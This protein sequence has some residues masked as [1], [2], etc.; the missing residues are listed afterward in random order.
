MRSLSC[1]HSM[2]DHAALTLRNL[3]TGYAAEAG[4]AALL[5]LQA[6]L[7][8]LTALAGVQL[9]E[10]GAALDPLIELRRLRH[11]IVLM[12]QPPADLRNFL[13]NAKEALTVQVDA[14]SHMYEEVRVQRGAFKKHTLAGLLATARETLQPLDNNDQWN[15]HVLRHVLAYLANPVLEAEL[16]VAP[17][18]GEYDY[19]HDL[20]IYDSVLRRMNETIGVCAVYTNVEEQPAMPQHNEDDDPLNG[21]VDD[22]ARGVAQATINSP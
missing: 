14:L 3:A 1:L 8:Q 16:T 6:A 20:A 2:A 19:Q 18:H 7:A 10:G 12:A 17:G 22:I 13:T 15:T 5:R 11:Q 9:N 4:D 21:S